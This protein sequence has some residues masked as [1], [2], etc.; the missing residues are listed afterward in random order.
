MSHFVTAPFYRWQAALDFLDNLSASSP[1][2]V[3]TVQ[4]RADGLWLSTENKQHGILA[5]CRFDAVVDHLAADAFVS[6]PHVAGLTTT[7]DLP[8][9]AT[10]KAAVQSDRSLD[11]SIHADGLSLTFSFSACEPTETSPLPADVPLTPI[12]DPTSLQW[13]LQAARQAEADSHAKAFGFRLEPLNGRTLLITACNYWLLPIAIDAAPPANAVNLPYACLN[14]FDAVFTESPPTHWQ[15][16]EWNN[17]PTLHLETSGATWIFRSN[18]RETSFP[19]WQAVIHDLLPDDARTTRITVDRR[20]LASVLQAFRRPQADHNVS[21]IENGNELAIAWS[22][23]QDNLPDIRRQAAACLPARVE[24]HGGA[25]VHDWHVNSAYLKTLLDH[26]DG[27]D[28]TLFMPCERSRAELPV[29]LQDSDA[30]GPTAYLM[31]RRRG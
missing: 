14:A 10:V 18:N 7:Q 17:A 22:P 3:L 25:N 21:L 27:D 28:V 11:L 13:A 24:R 15:I 1:V 5:A 31:M 8:P 12:V 20:K 16:T 26:V 19:D 23:P 6:L 29:Y 2:R 30:R 9:N 4:P